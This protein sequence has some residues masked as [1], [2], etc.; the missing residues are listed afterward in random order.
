MDPTLDSITHC[1]FMWSITSV[2]NP[3]NPLLCFEIVS[4]SI[5]FRIY[6]NS[7]FFDDFESLCR[8][9]TPCY[10]KIWADFLL[11]SVFYFSGSLQKMLQTVSR[12]V[13]YFSCTVSGWL[14]I[15][16]VMPAAGGH[17]YVYVTKVIESEISRCCPLRVSEILRAEILNPAGNV[18]FI[19]HFHYLFT[20]RSQ[21]ITKRRGK[22]QFGAESS[23][24]KLSS[25]FTCL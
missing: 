11:P 15:L 4:Y 19:H 21:W 16:C 24:S 17:F 10:S 9:W 1:D 23:C 14:I 18:F 2:I 20:V 5:I 13:E 25:Y 3:Y 12:N 8:L 7:D 6:W 22:S